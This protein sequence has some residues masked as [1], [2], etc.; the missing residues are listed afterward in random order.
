MAFIRRKFLFIA[1][2]LVTGCSSS[3]TPGEATQR[4]LSEMQQQRA[5]EILQQAVW[6]VDAVAGICGSRGFWYDENSDVN[7]TADGMDLLSHKRG[8]VLAKHPQQIGEVVVFEKQY[9]RYHFDFSSLQAIYLY[10]DPRLLPVFPGC[11]RKQSTQR[12]W[13]IDLYA[14]ETSNIKLTVTDDRFDELMAA[15]LYLFPELPVALK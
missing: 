6:P 7:V 13:I 14:A 4:Y 2:L 11:N 15:L 9:Y 8:K 3:Y 12:Y 1:A 10:R 5:I